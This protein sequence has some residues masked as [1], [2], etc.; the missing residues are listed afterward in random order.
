MLFYLPVLEI[1]HKALSEL[2]C[3]DFDIPL[4]KA[5]ALFLDR[6]CGIH[7]DDERGNFPFNLGV[8]LMDRNAHKCVRIVLD[9]GANHDEV[10]FNNK[11]TLDIAT[12]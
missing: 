11:K 3:C 1:Y 9:Y 2:Q 8:N 12:H 5:I 7:C 6:G 4:N 10:N